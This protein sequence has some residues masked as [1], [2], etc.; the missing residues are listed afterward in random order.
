MTRLFSLTQPTIILLQFLSFLAYGLR[1]YHNIGK[2]D[3]VLIYS[4]NSLAYPIL[5]LGT[6][7]AGACVSPA[8]HAYNEFELS[9]QIEDSE[10][11]FI[12]AHP[13]NMDLAIKTLKEIGW[14]ESKINER[15]VSATEESFGNHVPYTQLLCDDIQRGIPEK[16]DGDSAHDVALICYSSGTT[17]ASKGVMTTHRNFVTNLCQSDNTRA[18]ALQVNDVT[19]TF[20]PFCHIFGILGLLY[21]LGKQNVTQVLLPRFSLDAFGA[22]IEKYGITATWAVPPILNSILKTDIEK[23][24]DFSSLRV[25]HVGATPLGAALTNSFSDKLEGVVAVSN[26]Y[27]KSG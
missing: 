1:K 13:D 22:V 19:L 5:L 14:P 21:T 16:F 12:F 25:V 27:G 6:S 17:G 20:L 24:F 11:S 2:S 7:A 8:N 9:H 4:P 15:V 23:K 3:K 26:G 18:F 10:A